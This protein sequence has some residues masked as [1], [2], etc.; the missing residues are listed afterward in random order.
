MDSEELCPVLTVQIIDETRR[1]LNFHMIRN[2]I[3]SYIN[4]SVPGDTQY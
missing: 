2:K 3:T 1:T 4:D